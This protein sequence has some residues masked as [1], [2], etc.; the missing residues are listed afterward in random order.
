MGTSGG[1]GARPG[2]LVAHVLHA[3]STPFTN[4]G[5]HAWPPVAPAQYTA[6]WHPLDVLLTFRCELRRTAP[7]SSTVGRVFYPFRRDVKH[8]LQFQTDS[9]LGLVPVQQLHHQVKYL[10]P[11]T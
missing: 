9:W 3:C 2:N 11:G 4:V 10:P 1:F 8:R 5:S 7:S 6:F